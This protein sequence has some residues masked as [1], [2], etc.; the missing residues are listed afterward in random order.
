ME[1]VI[2]D[3][4]LVFIAMAFSMFLL[5]VMMLFFSDHTKEKLI[6]IILIAGFNMN[7]CWL[8]SFSFLGINIPGF[9]TGGNLINNPTAEMWMFFAI[10]LG[11][12]LVNIGIIFYSHISLFKL[13]GVPKS[14]FF[15]KDEQ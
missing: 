1:G 14:K 12:F 6:G 5:E 11:L 4:H 7:I 15:P 10:F 9:D 2:I 8:A 3:Y 13:K